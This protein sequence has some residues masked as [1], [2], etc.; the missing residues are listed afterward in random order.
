MKFVSLK[1]VGKGVRAST[2]EG[3]RLPADARGSTDVS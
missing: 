1:R 2:S 3:E